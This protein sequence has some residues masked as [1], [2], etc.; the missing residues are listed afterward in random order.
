VVGVTVDGLAVEGAVPAISIDGTTLVPLR[1][2]SE[3]LGANLEYDETTAA[4][5]VH[6]DFRARLDDLERKVLDLEVRAGAAEE[7][8]APAEVYQLVRP[9]VVSLVVKTEDE[10]GDTG[11]SRGT[12]VITWKSEDGAEAQVTTNGHVVEGYSEI[13]V[14][15]H[16]GR[17]LNGEFWSSDAD[18]DYAC[19]QIEG[20]DLPPAIDWGDPGAVDIGDRVMVIG[21]PLGYRDSVS[22]G[23]LSGKNREVD[24]SGYAYLQTD[25]PVNPGN[26]GGPLV[27]AWGGFIGLVTHKVSGDGVEGLGFAISVDSLRQAF[28]IGYHPE[29]QRA[30]LGVV[31]AESVAATLGARS[32]TGP[33]I[34]R[35]DPDGCLAKAGLR[36]GDEIVALGGQE[37]AYFSDVRKVVDTAL[38]GARLT[39]TYR[40][41]SLLVETQV[42]P[43]GLERW[44]V[45]PVLEDGPG[46]EDWEAA[47]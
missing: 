18:L 33:T 41:D 36:P 32:E 13:L 4:I 14:I 28:D 47:F 2:F 3:A 9:S 31:V 15:L 7:A 23:V 22:V 24:G 17:V 5:D 37:M 34:T 10:F 39:V 43:D 45:K 12:G 6:T 30:Y 35:L 29:Q 40:R 20:E 1:A 21:N 8:L 19:V 16:D 44:A 25:A 27:D 26:S 38:P 11:Y 42:V 46:L